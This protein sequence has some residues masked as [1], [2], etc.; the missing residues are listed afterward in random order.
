[1]S[2]ASWVIPAVVFAA[3]SLLY[4]LLGSLQDVPLVSPDEFLYGELSRSVADGDG[5][6]LYGTAQKWPTAL[7]IYV[8]APAWLG[9]SLESG[10][11]VAKAIGSVAAC[12]VVFPVWLLARRYVA[13][14]PALVAVVLTLAGTWMV[15]TAGLLTENLALPLSTACLVAAVLALREPDARWDWVALALAALATFARAQ[16]GVLFAILLG[17]LLLDALRAEDRRAALDARRIELGVLG[18]IVLGGVI[19]VLSGS[20]AGLGAYASVSDF[21]PS[22]GDLLSA[23][24]QQWLALVTMTAFLPLAVLVALAGQKASWR[25]EQ[26]APLL[27]V[28]VSAV[29]LL[30]LESGYFVAGLKGLDWSIER[31]VMY[32]APLLIVL[33][34]VALD[35]RRLTVRELAIAGGV[36]VLPLLATPEIRL[37]LEEG[38]QFGTWKHLDSL[39]GLGT[40]PAIALVGA[41]VVGAGVLLVDRAEPARAV[42]AAGTVLLVVFAVQSQAIW[43]WHVDY[44]DK[45]RSQYPADLSWVDNSAPGPTTRIYLFGSSPLFQVA[46]FFNED[47]GAVLVPAADPSAPKPAGRVCFWNADPR[48][49]LTVSPGC[50]VERTL[51]NDDPLAVMTFHDGRTIARDAMLGQVIAVPPQPR[52]QSILRL[53]C[54]RQTLRGGLDDSSPTIPRSGPCGPTMAVDVWVDK[55]GA[56]ELTFQGGMRSQTVENETRSWTL[57]PGVPTRVRV[58]VPAGQSSNGFDVDW[59]RSRGAPRVVGAAL[60]SGGTRTPLL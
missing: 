6:A 50:K 47:V 30:V 41:L 60:I 15:S 18:A 58:R 40:G 16:M 37:A 55:P 29:V 42:L 46:D 34:V 38:A 56:V 27:C 53:P 13:A 48:G 57:P 43:N 44:T 19:V 20:E 12:A 8:L 31:Y 1:M 54:P 4:I 7:Y 21:R 11:G 51:W 9:D 25:D 49:T 5:L 59:T 22:A 23:I 3:A 36:V 39:L 28:T 14:W 52:L 10:Y 32:A 35:R 33:T 17:A 45:F 2:R 26:L 24:A